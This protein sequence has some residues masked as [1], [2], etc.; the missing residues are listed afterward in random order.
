MKDR[1]EWKKGINKNTNK[2]VKADKY[3]LIFVF[4]DGGVIEYEITEILFY[5]DIYVFS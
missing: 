5:C 2:F 3:N 4:K 1:K